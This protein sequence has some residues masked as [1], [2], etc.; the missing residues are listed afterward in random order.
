MLQ[1]FIVIAY[2]LVMVALG[3][4][5]RRQ[6][7]NRVDYFVAGRKGS[8][9]LITGSLF[10]TIIGGSATVGVA[11]LGFTRGLT[12]VWWL[13][14]GSIGLVILGIF[15]AGKLRKFAL[16]TLPDLIELK[17]GR[18]VGMV[19][20]ALIVVA[21][22]GVIAGQIIAT[23][24]ILGA[25]GYGD[26]VLW[27]GIFTVVTVFYTVVGGQYADIKT[28]LAQGIIIFAGILGGVIAL[29]SRVGGIGELF[30]AVPASHASFPVSEQFGWYDLAAL[31]L[32]VGATYVAGPD[33]FSRMFSARD[34]KT[35]RKSV[36]ITAGLVAVFALL[37]VAV[38]MGMSV[39]YPDIAAE[40]AFPLMV[41]N[42]LPPVA[43]GVVLAGLVGATM[44]SADSCLLSAGTILTNNFIG[45]IKS[46][47]NEKQ[48][49]LISRAGVVVL[50]VL[51]LGLALFLKG[52]IS[53]LMFAYT[54]FTAGVIPLVI[55][56]F[57]KEKLKVT[58]LGALCAVIGGGG[59]ALYAKLNA[60]KYLD[61]GA[62]GI[63]VAL[64][65]V[66]SL[67]QNYLSARRKKG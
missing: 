3:I 24:K 20:S 34:E 17:Y 61:L 57:Y 36:F 48:V 49:L 43:G 66:V 67:V 4:L 40:Q 53:S 13:W 37:P 25:L 50:G 21:W 19:T 26:L 12:G 55:A 5:S 56:A 60:V 18:L 7:K 63:S 38:G 8:A 6:I 39:L 52:I 65:L 2:F 58:S 47:L 35:A 11:G 33:M 64:L 32:L 10:A 44:S 27:M 29:V 28:D 31:L 30:A 15:F 22:L 16:Y 51:S 1:L 54:V 46:D 9:L 42:V 62:L 23:G 59:T 14:V 41:A 45:K